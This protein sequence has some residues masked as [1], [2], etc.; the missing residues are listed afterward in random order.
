MVKAGLFPAAKNFLI[1]LQVHINVVK[2]EEIL[3]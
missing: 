2:K 1:L 3:I